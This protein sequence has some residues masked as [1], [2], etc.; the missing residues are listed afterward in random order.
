VFDD[1][2][3]PLITNDWVPF[4]VKH[5]TG[6]IQDSSVV[7]DPPDEPLQPWSP[8]LSLETMRWAGAE[9]SDIGVG[10]RHVNWGEWIP[11][12]VTNYSLMTVSGD[13]GSGAFLLVGDN[14]VWC[15]QSFNSVLTYGPVQDY[16]WETLLDWMGTLYTNASLEFT[17]ADYP[18]RASSLTN[19]YK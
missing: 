12:A 14:L 8:Q 17:A 6:Q 9:W 4:L 10:E 18:L 7:S 11:A 3:I 16:T 13:S 2:A 1:G 5:A 19:R 15:G